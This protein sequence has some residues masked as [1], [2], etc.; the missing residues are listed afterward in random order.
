MRSIIYDCVYRYTRIFNS[1]EYARLSPQVR[2]AVP[3]RKNE[4][5]LDEAGCAPRAVGAVEEKNRLRAEADQMQLLLDRADKLVK[6][7]AGENERWQISIG[8]FQG[9]ITRCLGNSLV[10]AAFLSYA[11]PFDTLYRSRLV[12]CRG[13]FQN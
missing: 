6:G 7:L 9:E 1:F 11:G 3:L 4:T 2:R 12:S 10:A 13:A 5:L 8:Q